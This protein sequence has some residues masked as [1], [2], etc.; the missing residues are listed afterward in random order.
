MLEY[1]SSFT[2]KQLRERLLE[3]GIE[4]SGKKSELVQKL[5]THIESEKV[6]SDIVLM[7]TIMGEYF[8][9]PEQFGDKKLVHKLTSRIESK[10]VL[11]NMSKGE[12]AQYLFDLAEKR[13]KSR[14]KNIFLM[15]IG[16]SGSHWIEAMLD[17][18]PRINC[19]N[20]VYFPKLLRR[21]VKNLDRHALNL[22]MNI[23]HLSHLKTD[24]ELQF[25][26]IIV[27]S[28][29]T[30][31]TEFYRKCD[32][33]CMCIMLIRDPYYI[34]VSRTFRKDSY[35]EYFAPD[36]NDEEYLEHNIFRV[37]RW[38]ERH[39][40]EYFDGTT[41]YEDF[42]LNVEDALIDLLKIMGV[43]SI[44]KRLVEQIGYRHNRKTILSGKSKNAANL[45]TGERKKVPEYLEEMVF[46]NLNDIRKVLN[47][48]D[49]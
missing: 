10:L 1:L 15:N 8:T 34:V 43:S 27:N 37:K 47:Y 13:M 12:Y 28:A 9:K 18:F 31:G 21:K 40:Q 45:Y 14:A 7:K 5:K 2:V 39:F 20:E 46:Q 4:N 23:I 41:K 19:I 35:R 36:A 26:S 29:H 42:I 30:L 22:M 17:E 32:D 16:S 6:V 11:K 38:Y 33:T 3:A 24:E 25:D 49:E 48:T 44:E